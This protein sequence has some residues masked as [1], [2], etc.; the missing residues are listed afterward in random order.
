MI[1]DIQRKKKIKKQTKFF[2]KVKLDNDNFDHQLQPNYL[3][4]YYNIKIE[5]GKNKNLPIIQNLNQ[6]TCYKKII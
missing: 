3:R 2:S 4:D 6:S 1:K 5:Q